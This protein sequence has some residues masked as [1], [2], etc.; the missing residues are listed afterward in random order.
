MSD[1]VWSIKNG[2]L[3]QVLALIRE[4]Q[5]D[6]NSELNGRYLLHYAA[7]YGQYDVL[8]Y[9]I[10]MGAKVNVK[11]KHDI[12]PL[13]AAIWEGHSKCVQLLI[14]K[15]ADKEGK[16]PDGSKYIDVAEK[17]EIRKLLL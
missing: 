10:S 16:T 7:D 8:D 6:I 3:D 13:L 12:T 17:E 4:K 9:L 2:E 14:E 5:V 1:L 11:D 15:G